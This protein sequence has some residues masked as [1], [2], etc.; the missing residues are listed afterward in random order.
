MCLF[1]ALI[2]QH[3]SEQQS[4]T[5]ATRS[6]T[7]ITCKLMYLHPQYMDMSLKPFPYQMEKGE[8]SFLQAVFKL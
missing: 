1:R 6:F 4:S 3:L 2:F 5:I 8:F 7:R